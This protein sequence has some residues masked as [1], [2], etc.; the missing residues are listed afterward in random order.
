MSFTYVLMTNFTTYSIQKVNKID[1]ILKLINCFTGNIRL[2]KFYHNHVT[3]KVY[4]S[5]A[6]V[7][8]YCITSEGSHRLLSINIVDQLLEW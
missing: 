4:V 8:F 1:T 3:Y 7:S 2:H 5:N 6:S